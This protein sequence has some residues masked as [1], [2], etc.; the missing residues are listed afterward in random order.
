[1]AVLGFL[2][3]GCVPVLSNMSDLVRETTTTVEG[4][5]RSPRSVP[6]GVDNIDGSVTAS[7]ESSMHTT[8]VLGVDDCPHGVAVLFSSRSSPR[9]CPGLRELFAIGEENTSEDESERESVGSGASGTETIV[10]PDTSTHG[11]GGHT[12]D[13]TVQGL[14]SPS[15]QLGSEDDDVIIVGTGTSASGTDGAQNVLL[16]PSM[17]RL[18]ECPA[19]VMARG[20]STNQSDLTG[21]VDQAECIICL[22]RAEDESVVNE[23]MPSAVRWILEMTRRIM[24]EM[25]APV[26]YPSG[27]HWLHCCHQPVHVTCLVRTFYRTPE[28]K[29]PHCRRT[30][31]S[32]LWGP[33]NKVQIDPSLWPG[34]FQ[35]VDE[36]LQR[37]LVLTDDE[38]T[39]LMR[40]WN[41]EE[42]LQED[43]ST[44]R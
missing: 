41:K 34:R 8:E 7:R 19:L 3:G 31:A 39:Q 14:G 28:W 11:T 6:E 43:F 35:D 20:T 18:Q 16:G 33:I 25:D 21:V 17:D 40:T 44:D 24:E 13:Q 2:F 5:R 36:F 9:S 22:H 30:L 15:G 4:A 37:R 29:C 10:L 23:D 38:I 26:Q 32:C 42:G 1:M 27:M 12:T